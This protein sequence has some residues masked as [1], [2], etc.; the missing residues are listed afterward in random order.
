MGH[1]DYKYYVDRY[2]D[3]LDEQGDKGAC[4]TLQSTLFTA[5]SKRNVADWVL[6]DIKKRRDSYRGAKKAAS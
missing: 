5:L 1:I 3:I 6:K 4:A 2:C